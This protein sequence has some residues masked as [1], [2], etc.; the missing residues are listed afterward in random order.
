MHCN[1]WLELVRIFVE[2]QNY[3]LKSKRN[4]WYRPWHSAYRDLSM[5]IS[6]TALE[7]VCEN[8]H[9]IILASLFVQGVSSW[10]PR[11][12]PVTALEQI[13]R[14]LTDCS[15][16]GSFTKWVC[17]GARIYSLRDVACNQSLYST[18]TLL[19]L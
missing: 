19:Q 6:N 10:K 13:F 5:L 3:K 2:M 9:N 16:V 4:N 12:R 14:M 17:S 8:L 11:H 15:I 1:S 18:R 7:P